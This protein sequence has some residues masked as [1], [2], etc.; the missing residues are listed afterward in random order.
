MVLEGGYNVQGLTKCVRAVLLEMIGET[1]V[2]E[3]TLSRTAGETGE[4]A[5]R[6]IERVREQ[7]APYWK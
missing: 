7:L 6:V 4:Q 1:R 3:G 5:D 2:T